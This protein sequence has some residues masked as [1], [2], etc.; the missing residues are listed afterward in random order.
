VRDDGRGFEPSLPNGDRG[1]GLGG[2]AERARL[3][4]GE[5]TIESRPG[6]GTEL[7]LRVP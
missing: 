2:M 1:L 3:V 4:G 6:G 5:L 7:C